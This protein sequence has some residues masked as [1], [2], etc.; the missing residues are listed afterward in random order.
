MRDNFFGEKLYKPKF[1][2]DFEDP[3]HSSYNVGK[4]LSLYGP[5]DKNMQRGFLNPRICI[6]YPKKWKKETEK[7]REDLE[8]GFEWLDK[9]FY[10]FFR[11]NSTV[12]DLKEIESDNFDSYKEGAKEAV[13]SAYDLIIFIVSEVMK[14]KEIDSPYWMAKTFT[15]NRGIPSQMAT[16]EVINDPHKWKNSIVNLSS[17]IYAKLGGTPWTLHTPNEET[18]LILGVGKSEYKRDIFGS[19]KQTIGFTTAYLNNGAFL[20]FNSSKEEIEIERIKEAI[21]YS[22]VENV[23]KI[24]E[25][26]GIEP[27]KIVIHSFKRPGSK[28]EEGIIQAISELKEAGKEI[29]VVLTWLNRFHIARVFDPNHWTGAAES[30]L[31]IHTGHTECIL[32]TDGRDSRRGGFISNKP[33]WIKN[34]PNKGDYE[35]ISS[36][37]KSIY[38]LCYVNWKDQFGSNIPI[39][40]KY[41]SDISDL[42]EHMRRLENKKGLSFGDELI[43]ERLS[44]TPW[45]L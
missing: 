14:Q 11:L 31:L 3:T 2:F 41:S 9:P 26:K 19:P 45:F 38:N 27:G 25:E 40:M 13:G 36:L 20:W 23:N 5:Y 34:F 4:G 12:F 18:A 24:K 30:S 17:Q 8:N 33:I 37:A 28:E 44:N 29:K 43:N 7:L 15:V 21:K 16:I 1:R 39:T 42:L 35:N 10:D 32:L 6:I 22:I